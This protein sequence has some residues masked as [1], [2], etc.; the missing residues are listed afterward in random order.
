VVCSSNISISHRLRD[1]ITFA[2]KFAVHTGVN[3]HACTSTPQYQS[4]HEI[5]L[6]CLASPI[7]KIWW[8]W[9]GPKI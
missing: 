9:V 6:T 8:I 3:Y 5:W 1:I 4:T 2:M 7:P